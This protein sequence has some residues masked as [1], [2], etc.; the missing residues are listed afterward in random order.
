VSN[1][2]Q[3]LQDSLVAA[4]RAEPLLIRSEEFLHSG[5]SRVT[6]DQLK[7]NLSQLL[8]PGLAIAEIDRQQ[9]RALDGEMLDWFR[10]AMQ[11]AIS[12]GANLADAEKQLLE[13]FGLRKVGELRTAIKS[14]LGGP[15]E[16]DER[17]LAIYVPIGG[18]EQEDFHGVL[19]RDLQAL[20]AEFEQAGTS[21]VEEAAEL[22][23]VPAVQPTTTVIDGGA[24]LAPAAEAADAG[25]D[26]R[27]ALGIGEPSVS[28]GGRLA[29]LNPVPMLTAALE[30]I[31]LG[32]EEFGFILRYGRYAPEGRNSEF[33]VG[34]LGL[35]DLSRRL[36]TWLEA[37][38]PLDGQV[39]VIDEGSGELTMYLLL[40][41]QV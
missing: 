13:S 21:L 5:R 35:A 33:L 37:Q 32:G 29:K 38:A 23:V 10:A 28:E 41:E 27:A 22:P 18:Q 11:G 26:L 2:V 4:L 16:L 7:D 12:G 8:D 15:A 25:T 19:R 24:G 6:P 40:P 14:R 34:G 17:D 9:F 20:E 1:D 31:G 3:L 39:Q 30:A 36:T